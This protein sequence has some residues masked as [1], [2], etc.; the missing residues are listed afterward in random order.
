MNSVAFETLD[1]LDDNDRYHLRREITHKYSQTK[2]LYYVRSD[3]C[4]RLVRVLTLR[5]DGDHV[6]ARGGRPG[7]G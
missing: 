4:G 3:P 7:Y 5:V 2:T 1:L 6:F